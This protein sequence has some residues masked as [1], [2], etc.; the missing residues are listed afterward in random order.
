MTST[1][2]TRRY[3]VKLVSVDEPAGRADESNLES[4]FDENTRNIE[5]KDITVLGNESQRDI[6]SIMQNLEH[7]SKT[8]EL[9]LYNLSIDGVSAMMSAL[10]ALT[11]IHPFVMGMVLYIS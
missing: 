9:G 5:A 10:E 1:H 6:E 2:N 8:Y 3:D 7:S 4:V 11:Q